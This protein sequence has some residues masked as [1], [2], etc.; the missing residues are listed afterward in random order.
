[1][2]VRPRAALFALAM[3]GVSLTHA[4]PARADQEPTVQ[5]NDQWPRFRFG[6][7]IM[8]VAVTIGS[9]ALAL[10][11]VH[12]TA[13][14]DAP[15]LFDKPARALF[16]S[17]DKDTQ[18][19]AG[20][21]SDRLYHGMVL[22]PYLVDNFIVALGVH[23]NADV[24]LQMTLIDLQSLGLSG[25]LA[26]GMEH[27][28][29]RARPY[30]RECTDPNG[31]DPVGYNACGPPGGFQGFPS[32]HAAAAFTM[33]GLTCVHHQHLPLWG[34]GWPDAA[35][36]IG[37]MALATTT[38]TLRLVVDRH[39]ATDI[40][41]GAAIGIFNGYFLPLWLHYGF[42]DKTKA[43]STMWKTQVGYLAPVPQLYSG[44]GGLGLSGSF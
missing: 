25:V 39:W 27:G 35:A 17:N 9:S 37:T 43:V 5:W 2:S 8:L 20:N 19:L 38:G 21:L 10:S 34:G 4:E 16:K 13:L 29:G 26:L 23:Q 6:E 31:F 1:M 18:E 28:L 30:E 41:A 22:A 15:I 44:G 40:V 33:A 7:G 32:G 11:P 14:W 36:C 3:A 12:E 24:A 42:G